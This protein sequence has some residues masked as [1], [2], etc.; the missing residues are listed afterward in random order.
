MYNKIEVTSSNLIA[1]H[2]KMNLLVILAFW[3]LFN[4]FFIVVGSSNKYNNH[5]MTDISF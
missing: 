1:K 4:F 3:E 5:F 2:G